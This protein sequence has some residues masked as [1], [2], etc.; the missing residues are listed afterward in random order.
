MLRLMLRTI[1]VAFIAASA[2]AVA[3]LAVYA[4]DAGVALD[5]DR[6]LPRAL[7]RGL[8][9]PERDGD[10]TFAWTS[11]D[12]TLLLRG[13]SRSAPWE[14]TWRVRGGR[15]AG[16]VQPLVQASVDG[17]I[18]GTTTATNDLQDVTVTV[19]ARPGADGVTLALTV[20]PTVVPGPGDARQLG[21]QVDR[22]GCRPAH[23]ELVVPPRQAVLQAALACALL[24]IAL[25]LSG[26]TFGSA[27]GGAIVIGAAQAL[28]LAAGPAPYLNFGHTAV[29]LA[30]WIAAAVVVLTFLLERWNG[31][32]LRNTARFAILFSAASL[33]LQVLGLLHPS[34]LVI[35]AVFHAHRLDWVLAGRYFFTQP[36][37]GGVSFPYAIGLYVFAAPW[38]LLTDDHVSLLRIVVTSVQVVAGALL[39][40]L[41]A[42]AWGERLAGAIAVALFSVVPLPYELLG[43]ANMANVFAQSVALAAVVAASTFALAARAYVQVIFFFLVVAL[44]FLSHVS[45]FAQ[46]AATLLVIA[47]LYMFRGGSVLR[48]PGRWVAAV[49]IVAAVFAVVLYYGHFA[50]VYINALRVRAGA[51]GGDAAGAVATVRPFSARLGAA[52]GLTGAGIGWP[53]LALAA[54]DAVALWRARSHDRATFAIIAWVCTYVLFVGVSLMRVDAPF[55]RY[56]AEF[57]GRVVLATYPAAVLLAARGAAWGWGSGLIARIAT[58]AAL[59]SA[60]VLGTACWRQW[61]T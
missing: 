29:L 46:L 19:P 53:I 61:F 28:P 27:V 31:S 54:C 55:Q 34:K 32:A 48:G 39:Y 24:G 26:I 11:G 60:V 37:P 15:G 7:A 22:V 4:R 9:P 42:R 12:A 59:I 33:Y 36:M 20:S 25:A 49:T 17:L 58:S 44:A 40:P 35:D 47:A 2:A 56:S 23:G 13:L 16:L 21:V 57:V 6:D 38:S 43:N 18:A 51:A 3:L 1:A 41:A 5:M 30:A 50:D 45:T 10:F 14:C 52:L 8:Y